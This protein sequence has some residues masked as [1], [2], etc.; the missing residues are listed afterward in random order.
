MGYLLKAIQMS[1]VAEL[2]EK[3]GGERF[4]HWL[5]QPSC[6]DGMSPVQLLD[7]GLWQECSELADTAID[8]LSSED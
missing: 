5:T 6:V 3:I 4:I 1:T 7:E 2:R 8:L